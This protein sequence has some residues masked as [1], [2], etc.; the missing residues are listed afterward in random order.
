MKSLEVENQHYILIEELLLIIF[1]ISYHFKSFII[2]FYLYIVPTYFSHNLPSTYTDNHNFEHNITYY[3][4]NL[5]FLRQ[6]T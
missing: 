6:S 2:I 3:Q 4:I 5:L 1:A